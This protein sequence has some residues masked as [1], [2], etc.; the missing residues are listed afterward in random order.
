MK[1]KELIEIH[2]LNQ[3]EFA[4]KIGVSQK[5]I[6]NYLSGETE[7]TLSI[8]CKMAEFFGVSLDYLCDYK[9]DSLDISYYSETAKTIIKKMPQLKEENLKNLNIICDGLIS[10]QK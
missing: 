9:I 1:L 7:P 6:S 3:T 4:Q 2:N 10:G 8:L 5:T